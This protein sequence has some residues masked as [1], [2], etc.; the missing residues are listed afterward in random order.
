MTTLVWDGKTA[1]WDSQC[2]SGELKYKGEKSYRA[3]DG[4]L[5]L[6]CGDSHFLP[7]CAA[8]YEAGEGPAAYPQGDY[9]LLRVGPDGAELASS[10]GWLPQGN[11]FVL[12]S[13]GMAALAALEMGADAA[14]ACEVA[15]AVD[16]YSSGPVHSWSPGKRAQRARKGA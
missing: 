16:L 10:D 5:L 2:T 1:A 13:G 11:R 6:S 12:G 7:L 8:L 3:K 9:S 14:R 15:C 4:K